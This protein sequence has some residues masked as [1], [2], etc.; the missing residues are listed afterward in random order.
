MAFFGSNI[1]AD[2]SPAL[3]KAYP[4]IVLRDH[5]LL[6]LCAEDN[7]GGEL[8]NIPVRTGYTVGIGTTMSS[9]VAA[10]GQTQRNRFQVTPINPVYLSSDVN[11]AQAEWSRDSEHAAV[12]IIMDESRATM[13]GMADVIER[14][15][16]AGDGYGTIAKISSHSGSTP[17][18]VLTMTRPQDV[19]R[20]VVNRTYVSK[21]TAA[22][23]SLDAGTFIAAAIDPI[24]GTVNATG[25]GTWAPTDGHVVGES[26]VMAASTAFQVPPGLA[27]WNP[28]IN[29]RPGSSDSFF[30]FNRFSNP[31]AA[32]GTAID[33]TGLPIKQAIN[34][35]ATA[36]SNT[37][38][39]KLD[40]VLLAPPDYQKLADD[41]GSAIEFVDVM[42]EMG[43]N[44]IG[45][46]LAAGKGALSIMQDTF[47]TAGIVRAFDSRV[48]K[49]KF[50][51]KKPIE[52]KDENG[53]GF[54]AVTTDDIARI[55]VRAN[56]VFY[57]TNPAALGNILIY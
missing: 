8:V 31:Q 26:N 28:D 11:I 49:V 30:G 29:N 51:G 17:N 22:A 38:G 52:L 43:V 55:T 23:S 21:A 1:S 39:F 50:P 12:D 5:P 57:P 4:D 40:T 41:L 2:L 48:L 9:A 37:G 33:G 53:A 47:A 6:G 45:I 27:G 34:T 19:Y 46:R 24:A 7:G 13:E 44:Y 3:E 36:M 54:I 18:F 14:I 56:Y 32:A 20:F 16:A 10:N 15:L 35:L 25:D 42:G